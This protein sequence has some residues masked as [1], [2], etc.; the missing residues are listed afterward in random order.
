MG[1]RPAVHG[2]SRRMAASLLAAAACLLHLVAP[3][4]ASA[5]QAEAPSL[6]GTTRITAATT[7]A[8]WVT[9]P[10]EARF[11]WKYG[12]NPDVTVEGGGRLAAV[13]LMKGD[14]D[15]MNRPFV[16]AGRASFCDTPGCT[17]DDQFQ[18]VVGHVPGATDRNWIV[19][20]PGRYL[21]YLIAD[22]APASVTLRLHGLSGKSKLTPRTPI[23]ADFGV[24]RPE[25][26]VVGPEK[27]VYWFGDSGTI[28]AE[29]GLVLGLMSIQAKGWIQGSYGSCLQRTLFSPEP[30]A[31]SPACPGGTP[32]RTTE[33]ISAPGDRQIHETSIWNVSPGGEW[34][35][36]MNYVAAADVQ[37]VAA[38]TLWLPYQA[39]PA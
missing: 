22:G 32:A 36:G 35:L 19:L 24:P 39:P 38:V 23:D 34:G 10:Q 20:Q 33:G 13:A 21:L 37:R 27:K 29:G 16:M 9:V 12:P 6:A 1:H 17:S 26:E 4:R 7:S 28:D 8:M 11:T 30:V 14:L 25:T 18:F 31:Y 2:A 3:G 15:D 5:A